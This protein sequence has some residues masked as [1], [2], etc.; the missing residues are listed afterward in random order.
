MSGSLTAAS[1][2][3]TIT[4]ETQPGQWKSVEREFSEPKSEKLESCEPEA[5]LGGVDCSS[6]VTEDLQ[7]GGAGVVSHA[8]SRGN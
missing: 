7:D 2:H 4:Q 3:L 5:N 8:G 6:V 1:I